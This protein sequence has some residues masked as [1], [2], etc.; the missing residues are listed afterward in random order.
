MTGSLLPGEAPVS[1]NEARSWLRLG[2]TTEDAVVAQLVRA[3]T[4]ICEAFIG[5]W[6]IVRAV[7]ELLPR[8]ADAARLGARPVVAVDAAVL[9]DASG[10][11]TALDAGGY[12]V[13]IGHDGTGRVAVH[14]WGDATMLRVTYRA[15][16]AEGAN[17]VPEAI[18][19]GIIRMMQYLHDARDGDG[20]APPA[21]VAALWRPWRSVTLGGGQ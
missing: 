9:L 13:A 11:E 6:L 1:L 19:Q 5:R 10:G 17:A 21:A 4:G 7:E 18:R 12:R 8:R 20:T 15:G 3:A 16:M 14:D 2:M